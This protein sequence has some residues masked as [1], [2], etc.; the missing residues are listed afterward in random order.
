[1][2]ATTTMINKMKTLDSH[3]EKKANSIPPIWISF[4]PH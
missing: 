2:R 1:M 3:V 4:S